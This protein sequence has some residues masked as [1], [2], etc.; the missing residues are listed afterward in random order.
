MKLKTIEPSSDPII[1]KPLSS[2]TAPFRNDYAFLLLL[3]DCMSYFV[4]ASCFPA[5][6][7]SSFFHVL[8]I[9]H[10]LTQIM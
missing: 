1:S 10:S 5:S 9:I 6:N 3:V 7:A 2:L 8:D 4:V